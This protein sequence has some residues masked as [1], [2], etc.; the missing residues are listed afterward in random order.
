LKA[1][2]KNLLKQLDSEL[3]PVVQQ[4]I[5]KCHQKALN[6]ERTRRLPL[7][8]TYPYPRSHII[9]PF[10]HRETFDDPEKMLFNELVHAFDTSILLHS[11]INDDLPF[12]IRANFGTVIVA[13]LFGAKVERR[14]DNPPW[15]RHFETLEEFEKIF[16]VDPL[17]HSRGL[18]RQVIARYRF[19]QDV[20]DDYSNLKQCLRIVLPDLQGPLDTL[21]QLRGS[22][23]YTD[24]ILHPEMT[25]NGLRS[26]ARAQVGLAKHLQ[27]YTTG[28][29]DGI[30]YQHATATK[31]NILIRNDA[32]I[33]ISPE[34]YS[35]QIAEHD[36]YVLDEMQGGGI[37]SCGKI[38]FNIPEFFKLHNMECF[39]F[40][41]SH[42]NDIDVIY[43]MAR[44]R[45]IPLIRLSAKREDLEN[46]RITEKYP[47]GVSLVYHAGSFEEAQQI[48]MLYDRN[49]SAF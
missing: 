8:V 1:I 12:T 14:D 27:Q 5:D 47:T 10:P 39:D 42:L 23:I 49:T 36:A 40:G 35:Q 45:K 48:T 13:S 38:D 30:S 25:G 33:M 21:E 34:M 4:K 3:D 16:D 44:E 32:A 17:D 7:V 31:G 6:Y 18:C 37:H 22:E 28:S 29:P 11:R 26:I 41:Q 46:D 20:L 15:I 24:L 9:Q 19:Y 2:L 43:S